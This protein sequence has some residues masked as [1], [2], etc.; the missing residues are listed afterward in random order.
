MFGNQNVHEFKVFEIKPLKNMPAN[1]TSTE[2]NNLNWLL[3]KYTNVDS[4]PSSLSPLYLSTSL[5]D[6]NFLPRTVY[7]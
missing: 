7:N 1:R 3:G 6:D 4:L 2:E 5:I